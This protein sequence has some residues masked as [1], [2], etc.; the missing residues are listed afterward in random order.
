MFLFVKQ[1][2]SGK[3]YVRRILKF[4][5]GVKY[6]NALYFISGLCQNESTYDT[7]SYLIEKNG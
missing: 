4:G 5:T 2:I 3:L 7:G 6:V 1:K